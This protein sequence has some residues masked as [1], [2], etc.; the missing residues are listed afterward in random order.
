MLRG[1]FSPPLH[2]RGTGGNTLGTLHHRKCEPLEKQGVAAIR[3]KLQQQRCVAAK[4][5]VLL[6]R[7][8]ATLLLQ[9][10]FD[11]FVDG[12][13]PIATYNGKYC[14]VEIAVWQ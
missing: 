2:Q 1:P 13:C 10:S 3:T 8:V 14:Y 6:P 7:C 5:E 11:S 4:Y 9:H 12:S